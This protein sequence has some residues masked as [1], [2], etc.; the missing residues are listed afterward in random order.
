M[1]IQARGYMSKGTD[2]F[3]LGVELATKIRSELGSPKAVVAYLTVHHDQSAV[4]E[5]LHSVLGEVPLIGSSAQGVMGVGDVHEDGYAASV[6]AMAGDTIQTATA[7]AD[8][9]HVDTYAKGRALGKALRA[10]LPAPARAVILHYDPLSGADIGVFLDGVHA[11]LECSVYGGASSHFFGVP[12]TQTFQYHGTRVANRGAVAMALTG[13][14]ALEAGICS[15]CS[16]VG[17]E[18]TVTRA[19]GNV[20]FELDGR[21]ALEVWREITD[22]DGGAPNSGETSSLA[23]GIPASGNDNESGEY[24]VRAVIVLDEARGAVI[25]QTSIAE[26]TRV[27]LHHRTVDDVRDGARR[28]ARDLARRLEGKTPRVAFGFECGARTKPFLGEDETREEN[29][30]IQQMIAPDASWVGMTCWGELY[31][32]AGRPAYHN[33]TYPVLV[34]AD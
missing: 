21:P 31:P 26:G 9:I 7:M 16:T 33:Y 3:G 10:A 8:E 1:T 18:M 32:T 27:M 4:L 11:E 20:L 28:L 29:I 25:L 15:G 24:N 30:E 23:I 19:E 22:H 12:M 6:L 5:G 14:F 17:I 13:D 2:S 34:L